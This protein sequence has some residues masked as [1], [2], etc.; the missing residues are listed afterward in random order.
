MTVNLANCALRFSIPV[1]DSSRAQRF[2]ED[3]L[4][5]PAGRHAGGGIM[6]ECNGGYFALVQTGTAGSLQHSLMTWLV[7][8]IRAAVDELRG[9]G[10]IFETYDMP[11]F[12]TEDGIATFSNSDRVAWFK[13]SEGN[14]LALAQIIL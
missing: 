9:K 12:K 6:Y 3:V 8:D 1:N 7:E 2:Y 5:L 13:D 4:G 10:V 11:G 14:L